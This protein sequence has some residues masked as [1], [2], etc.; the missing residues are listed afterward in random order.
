MKPVDQTI[1]NPDTGNC[2]SAC[3]AS[4]IELE[5]E[6]VPNFLEIAGGDANQMFNLAR[7][8]TIRNFGCTILRVLPD[9]ITTDTSKPVP[10][11]AGGVA[12]HYPNGF[13]AVVGHIRGNGT[14][15]LDH[16]PSQVK[17]GLSG[18]PLF[19]YFLVPVNPERLWCR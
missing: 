4:I 3:L 11:I 1:L 16:D 2:F 12:P 9:G 7:A 13:H 15:V 14:F 18:K 5:L 17:A 6:E 8:W 10:C 19:L